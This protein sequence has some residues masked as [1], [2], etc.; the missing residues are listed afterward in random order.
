MAR[1]VT[2]SA[3]WGDIKRTEHIMAKFK[4]TGARAGAAKW[5]K[6]L[7]ILMQIATRPIKKMYGN[8]I[9][10]SV[11]V[12]KNF[13]EET[14]KP[15]AIIRIITGDKKIPIMAVITNIAAS[16]LIAD[17]ANLKASFLP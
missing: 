17:L 6:T 12:S 9:R 10:V 13:S 5:S 2:G 16:S 7:R 4:R 14:V 11:T 8:I 3:M 15:G 1:P